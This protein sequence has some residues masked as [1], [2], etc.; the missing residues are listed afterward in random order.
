MDEDAGPPEHY[1]KKRDLY[2][3]MLLQS[4]YWA[5]RSAIVVVVVLGLLAMFSPLL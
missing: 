5:L 2:S 3:G 1:R 4:L